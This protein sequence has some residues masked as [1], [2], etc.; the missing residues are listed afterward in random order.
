M[1]PLLGCAVLCFE[2]GVIRDTA[3]GPLAGITVI[4]ASVVIAVP[5]ACLVLAELGAEVIKVE[6]LDTLDSA[7]GLGAAPALGMAGTVANTARGKQSVVLNLKT[8]EGK[9]AFLKMISK[10]QPVKAG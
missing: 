3:K 5:T 9:E 7:R 6:T 1:I 4:D 2:G 10:A 8:P